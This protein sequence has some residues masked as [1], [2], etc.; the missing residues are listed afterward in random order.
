ML[1]KLFSGWWLCPFRDAFVYVPVPGWRCFKQSVIHFYKFLSFSLKNPS[2]YQSMQTAFLH[3]LHVVFAPSIIFL[4]SLAPSTRQIRRYACDYF[5]ILPF[6]RSVATTED[7]ALSVA[8]ATTSK[9]GKI[10]FKWQWQGRKILALDLLILIIVGPLPILNTFF[11]CQSADDVDD[12]GQ[13]Q[14]LWATA[15]VAACVWWCDT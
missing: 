5:N 11:I 1:P 4:L 8:T 13:K 2:N 6:D 14:L 3:G 15:A 7:E 10:K 12:D 9:S